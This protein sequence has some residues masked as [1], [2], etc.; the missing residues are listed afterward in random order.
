M[1]EHIEESLHHFRVVGPVYARSER[2]YRGRH[3]LAFATEKFASAFGSLFREF[4]LNLCPAVCDAVRDKLRITGFEAGGRHGENAEQ[5]GSRAG[6]IWHRNRMA[7]RSAEIH[8]EALVGGDAYAIVW[9][10]AEGRAAIYQNRA[11]NCTVVYDE[12]GR[13]RI[14]RAAKFWRTR[15][16]RTRLNIYYPDRIERFVTARPGEGALPSAEEFVPFRSEPAEGSGPSG[17][18]LANPYGIVPVFHFANNGE[19]GSFGRSELE[20]AIPVQ[21]G[22][23]KSVLDMMVAMEFAAYRQRWAAGIEVQTDGEGRP[24]QPFKPGVDKLWLAQSPDARFGDFDT[25]DLDQF[26]KVKDSFRVDIASVT[27]TP[28][29]YLLP[30]VR[31]FP[32]GE[33]QRK[34]ETRFIAKV[35]NRQAVFGHTWAEIMEFAL[36]IETGLR[37]AQVKVL[38]EDPSAFGEREMLEN[39]LLRRRLI[40][41]EP[42]NPA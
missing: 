9:P 21:D 32:S 31:S 6:D 30:S 40:T 4:A 11:A 41:P 2:Y 35:R 25:A 38:W 5:I 15:E 36:R 13:G 28:L 19:I 20:S 16:K 23:N 39:D 26:I 34:A 1:K 18:T 29:Y 24:D 27:G 37:P 33:A 10:D 8:R 22:L 7:I 17:P 14:L 42:H 3:D 12:E